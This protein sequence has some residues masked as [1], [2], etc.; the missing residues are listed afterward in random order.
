MN[1]ILILVVIVVLLLGGWYFLSLQSKQPTSSSTITKPDIEID[2][3]A[4]IPQT[5]R[6][7]AG[8]TIT[9]INNDFAS[10]TVTADDGTSF[11]TGLIGNGETVTFTAPSTPGQYAYHCIPHPSMKGVLVVE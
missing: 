2:G 1:K 5:F 7:K 3:Q 6:V 4:F 11:D 8:Q 9:V 10:H